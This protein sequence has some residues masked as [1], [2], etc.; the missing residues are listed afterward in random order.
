MFCTPQTWVIKPVACLLIACL[1]MHKLVGLITQ[2][3]VLYWDENV[4]PHSV[5]AE[6]E[7]LGRWLSLRATNKWRNQK[8]KRKLRK[9]KHFLHPHTE[10]GTKKSECSFSHKQIFRFNKI[11]LWR[12]NDGE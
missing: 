6:H 7:I 1:P 9:R 8:V 11:V 2:F 12:D 4:L 3:E 10:T 5:E